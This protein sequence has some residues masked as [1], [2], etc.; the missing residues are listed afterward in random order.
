MAQLHRELVINAPPEAVFALLAQPER[1]PE[2]TPGVIAVLITSSGPVGVGTTTET[3]MEAF[4]VRQTLVGRCTIFEPSRRL[5]VSNETTGGIKVGSV[6]IGKV[7]STS[8]SEL[9]PEG[10]GTRLRATLEYKLSA[11]MFSRLAEQ[12]VGPK[13]KEDFE[14][15]LKTLKRLLETAPPAG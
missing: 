13:M 7:Q 12:L 6:T 3:V 2:W 8:S 15:S 5:V 11:G 9:S 1:L 4:G 14:Q 10:A